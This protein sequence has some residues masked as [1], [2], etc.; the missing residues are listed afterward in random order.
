MGQVKRRR[1][2]ISWPRPDLHD[3]DNAAQALYPNSAGRLAAARDALVAAG[4]ENPTTELLLAVSHEAFDRA[5]DD[6]W[7]KRRKRR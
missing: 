2:R 6:E 5:F 7:E 4:F 3:V 1:R